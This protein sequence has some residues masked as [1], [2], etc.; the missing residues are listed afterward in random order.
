[1]QNKDAIIFVYDLSDNPK[2]E[3]MPCSVNILDQHFLQL[4][5]QIYRDDM[6]PAMIVGN[7]CD[8]TNSSVD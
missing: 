7:K 1:M 3:K 6:I 4:A 5:K 2:N 8:E